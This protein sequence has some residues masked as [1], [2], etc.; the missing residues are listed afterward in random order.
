MLLVE[1]G[2]AAK[3][4]GKEVRSSGKHQGRA[5][6][7]QAP[8][9]AQPPPSA[10]AA[11]RRKAATHKRGRTSMPHMSC[12]SGRGEQGLKQLMRAGNQQ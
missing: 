6:S 3:Q 12:G 10:G 1:L 8:A 2:V 9:A 5:A 11:G 7:E 4:E